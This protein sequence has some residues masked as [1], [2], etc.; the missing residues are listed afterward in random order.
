VGTV[1]RVVQALARRLVLQEELGEQVVDVLARNLRP[2]W[3]AC[4]LT[5]AHGCMIARG[6][7]AHRARIE[8]ISLRGD[9]TPES[10]LAV[11]GPAAA[12]EAER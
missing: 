3:A 6:E 12:R 1:V 10:A 7:R 11:L 8:T 2:T 4:R 5:L 9:V